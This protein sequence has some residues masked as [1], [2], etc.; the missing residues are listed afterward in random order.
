MWKYGPKKQS[1]I[2]FAAVEI[3]IPGISL[4]LVGAA[5]GVLVVA[6]NVGFNDAASQPNDGTAK[7]SLKM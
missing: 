5:C 4:G 7:N 1:P 3:G 2:K 6:C